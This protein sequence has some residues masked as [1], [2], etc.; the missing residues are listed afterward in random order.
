MIEAGF[1]ECEK[2]GVTG[3][4][5]RLYVEPNTKEIYYH[6]FETVRTHRPLQ[7]FFWPTSGRS[8]SCGSVQPAFY[9]ALSQSCPPPS[10]FGDR[11]SN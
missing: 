3:S 1:K 2:M 8:S 6:N 10:L 4:P 7:A 9:S 5:W 11:T